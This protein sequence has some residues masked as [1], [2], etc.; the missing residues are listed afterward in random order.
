MFGF[1][2]ERWRRVEINHRKWWTGELGRP[3]IQVRLG[4]K[5]PRREAPKVLPRVVSLG[6][7]E[8]VCPEDVVDAWDYDLCSTE[9]LGDAIPFACPMYGSSAMAVFIGT[10]CDVS[11]NTIWHHPWNEQ[12]VRKMRIDYVLDHPSYIWI[13]QMY[14]AAADKWQ[15]G[16]QLGITNLGGIYDILTM[17]MPPQKLIMEMIDNPE[18]VKRLAREAHEVWWQYFNELNGMLM[19]GNRAYADFWIPIMCDKPTFLLQSDFCCMVGLHMFDEFIKPELAASCAKMGGAMFHLDGPGALKHLDSLLEIP[20]LKAI[21]WIPGAGAPDVTQ[22]PE[23]FAKIRRAGKL[24]HLVGSGAMHDLD[25]VAEQLGSAEGLVYLAEGQ[26]GQKNQ[27]C[28]W[29][30]KY[31]ISPNGI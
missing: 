20:E 31:G 17:I 21:Q 12:D 23:I 28:E 27:F 4:G 6:Y 14:Q 7:D 25:V 29:L 18:E 19:R 10:R 2:Q 13:K 26:I 3:L 9:F 16:A 24:I 30:A 5:D 8:H 11:E 15:G 1:D 22:W